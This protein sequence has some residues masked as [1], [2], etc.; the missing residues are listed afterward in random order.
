MSEKVASWYWDLD[1]GFSH[2]AWLLPGWLPLPSFRKRDSA[3]I[4]IKKMFY[5]VIAQRRASGQREDDMLQTLM[6]GTY[7]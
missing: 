1:G 3:H 2:E 6:E 5:S 7:K 4:K